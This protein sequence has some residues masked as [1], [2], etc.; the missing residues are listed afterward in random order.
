MGFFLSTSWNAFRYEKAKEMLFEIR[1]LGY[2]GLELSFNLTSSM[3]KEIEEEVRKGEIKVL[4]LHNFCPTPEGF[5]RFQALPDCYSM[6]SAD[7]AERKLAVKF[8]KNSIDTAER[9]NA[10]ALVLHC[11]RVEMPNETRELIDLFQNKKQDSKRFSEL[12][13]ATKQTRERLRSKF[14]ENSLKSLDKLNSYARK[15]R[16]LLGV[17]TRCYYREIPILEEIGII[18]ERFKGSN[19]RYWHDVGHAQIMENLGFVRH[20]DFLELYGKEMIGIHL[21]DILG[22]RDHMAPSKGEFDFSILKP[23]LKENTLKILEV[24]H[25]ATAE[26]LKKAKKFLGEVLNEK[27]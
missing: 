10:K 24:H 17:E 7:E 11:G 23:Y 27:A 13:K 1:D 18:L 4:S 25:P 6:A 16:I 19:I 5:N 2:S 9:L 14:F 15:K 21:H 12:F 26:D 8:T 20:K 22:C 3:V